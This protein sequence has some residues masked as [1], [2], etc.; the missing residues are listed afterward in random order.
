MSAKYVLHMCHSMSVEVS[1][2]P[3]GLG[4]LHHMDSRDGNKCLYPLSY[5]QPFPAPL[6]CNETGS[7][8]L[9]PSLQKERMVLWREAGREGHQLHLLERRGTSEVKGTAAFWMS[10][11][12]LTDRSSR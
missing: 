9:L 8:N 1:R 4:S 6:K 3:V 10:G 11:M 12:E 7:G 2:Q 5:P